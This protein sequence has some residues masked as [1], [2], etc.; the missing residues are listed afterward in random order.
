MDATAAVP[1]TDPEAFRS[2]TV[3]FA[4]RSAG[5]VWLRHVGEP[6]PLHARVVDREE[7]R[8]DGAA[9]GVVRIVT[10]YVPLGGLT[11]FELSTA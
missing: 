5:D 11:L 6:I 4:V 3:V 1:T 9:G 10:V 7:G 8:A 2:C